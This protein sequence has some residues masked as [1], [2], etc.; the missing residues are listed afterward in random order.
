MYG[1][2]SNIKYFMA[3]KATQNSEYKKLSDPMPNSFSYMCYRGMYQGCKKCLYTRVLFTKQKL[4][5]LT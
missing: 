5:K 3:L 4:Y 2:F 1:T